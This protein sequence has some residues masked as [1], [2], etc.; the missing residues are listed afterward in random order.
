[1]VSALDAVGVTSV[2]HITHLDNLSSILTRGLLSKQ[3]MDREGLPYR[4]ISLVTAQQRRRQRTVRASKR[5][6]S[7]DGFDRELHEMVPF[8]FNPRNAMLYL[9]QK[10]GLA[11]GVIEVPVEAICDGNR[12]LAFSNGNMASSTSTS[13]CTFDEL[14]RVPWTDVNARSWNDPDY[15]RKA[16]LRHRTCA[17]FLV[18]PSIPEDLITKIHVA[19]V[20]A[21]QAARTELHKTE[22]EVEIVVSPNLFF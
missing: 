1:M 19:D 14:P 10:E 20:R 9:R 8:Y 3:S 15:E 18:T 12:L 16:D 22:A 2:F 17:E 6:E 11:L 5:G 7:L 4:D 21:A 13:S